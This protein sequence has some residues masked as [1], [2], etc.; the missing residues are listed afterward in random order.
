MIVIQ[1]I[2]S[3]LCVVVLLMTFYFLENISHSI[4]SSYPSRNFPT[5]NDERYNYVMTPLVATD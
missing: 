1:D 4:H 5:E 3:L 2:F